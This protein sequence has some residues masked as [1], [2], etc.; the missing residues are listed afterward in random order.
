MKL[1]DMGSQD[2]QQL[3]Q[4]VLRHLSSDIDEVSS[5][6]RP[7]LCRIVGLFPMDQQQV[8]INTI[9]KDSFVR[10]LFQISSIGHR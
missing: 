8:L 10:I 6:V 4:E 3:F 1:T 7:Q 9:I 2:N 5:K